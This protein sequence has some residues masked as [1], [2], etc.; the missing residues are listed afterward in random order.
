MRKK[1]TVIGVGMVGGSTVQYL[2]KKDYCDIVMVD[3]VEGMPQGKALDLHQAGPIEGFDGGLI[4]TTNYED[5]AGRT[6]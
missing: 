3:V 5:T 2:A 4:G 6:S 1:V